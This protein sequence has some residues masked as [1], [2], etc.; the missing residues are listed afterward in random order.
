MDRGFQ[1][2]GTVMAVQNNAVLNGYTE[3][4]DYEHF[5]QTR[6]ELRIKVEKITEFSHAVHSDE[7]LV[8]LQRGP[9]G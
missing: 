9:K 4:E 8:S 7:N 1:L 3:R 6:H 2:Q 5:P